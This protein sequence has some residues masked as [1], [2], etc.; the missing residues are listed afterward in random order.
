LLACAPIAERAPLFQD[1]NM[2][3]GR[4]MPRQ[5]LIAAT[6]ALW[7]TVCRNVSMN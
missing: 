4:L 1:M 6:S 2:Q 3:V 5:R 7:N